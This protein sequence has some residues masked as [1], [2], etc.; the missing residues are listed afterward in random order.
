[1]K[2]RKW[3]MS[4]F[5]QMIDISINNAWLVYK[6]DC[7]EFN[8][9]PTMKLKQFRTNVAMTSTCQ[10]K[11]KVGRRPLSQ[12]QVKKIRHPVAPRSIENV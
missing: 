2:N 7:K 12:D 3:C 10:N 6:R 4:L 5:L 11:P 8:E 1:M 9:K